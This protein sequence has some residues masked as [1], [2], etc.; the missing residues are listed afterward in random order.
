MLGQLLRKKLEV[1]VEEWV[2]QGR[3]AGEQVTMS[4]GGSDE[5]RGLWEWAGITAN[6]VA[7]EYDWG[8]DLDDDEDEEDE[9]DEKDDASEEP[10]G[11][12]LGEETRKEVI[13]RAAEKPMSMDD[14][15]KFMARG[16]EI[17]R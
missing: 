2:E 13:T 4:L 14:V 15:M 1:G 7:R 10:E 17:K 3:E 16:E 5:W 11:K 6:G 9:E 12:Q 8:G